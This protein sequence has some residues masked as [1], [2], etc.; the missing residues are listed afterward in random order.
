MAARNLRDRQVAEVGQHRRRL[1]DRLADPLLVGL[2]E[3]GRAADQDRADHLAPHDQRNAR[4]GARAGGAHR[5]RQQG[6]PAA[7]L[8]VRPAGPHRQAG[9]R[10]RPR[11]GSARA[12]SRPAAAPPPPAGPRCCC[13][14][15][16]RRWSW[17]RGSA[18]GS[19]AAAGAPRPRHSR[20][21]SCRRIPPGPDRVAG[22]AGCARRR[23]RAGIRPPAG[24]PTATPTTSQII[25]IGVGGRL[26]LLGL[27]LRLLDQE[28]P[29]Q[30]LAER[31][32]IGARS[33]ASV[34]AGW[35]ATMVGLSRSRTAS[36]CRTNRSDVGQ[37]GGRIAR[38]QPHQS[39]SPRRRW[40]AAGWCTASRGGATGSPGWR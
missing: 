32:V 26:H 3:G 35:V 9:P 4:G 18:P 16:P 37:L 13:C 6:Q 15:A 20:S 40:S 12:A 30:V 34:A 17:G 11:A 14:S 36:H 10:L 1:A 21:S 28:Q 29:V 39:R 25:R 27:P 33:V 23:G 5:A 38:V 2:V 31:Q 7:A 8:A 24:R 22:P 19:A